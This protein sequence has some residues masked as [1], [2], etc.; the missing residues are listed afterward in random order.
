M[1]R[2]ALCLTALWAAIPSPSAP[3]QKPAV[4]IVQASADPAAAAPNQAQAPQV[5]PSP[6][7]RPS[8][9]DTVTSKPAAP[10]KDTAAAVKPK[11][12][13]DTVIVVKHEFHHREQIITGSVIMSC[14]ALILV[15]MNNYNP[16]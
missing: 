9:P 12:R 6:E 15:A 7:P 3:L 2:T 13:S 5:T 10:P 16:R 4:P 11:S 8:A 1:L 14:L